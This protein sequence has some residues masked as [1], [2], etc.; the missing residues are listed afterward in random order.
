M[1]G[2]SAPALDPLPPLLDVALGKD[3][4]IGTEVFSDAVAGAREPSLCPDPLNAAAGRLGGA[5]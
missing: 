4:G 1:L 2:L 5:V 3:P